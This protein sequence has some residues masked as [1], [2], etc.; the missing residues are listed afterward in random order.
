MS[1]KIPLLHSQNVLHSEKE[2][3][4]EQCQLLGFMHMNI[5]RHLNLPC[6]FSHPESCRCHEQPVMQVNVHGRSPVNANASL[7][8]RLPM[9]VHLTHF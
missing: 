9:H 3:E 1:D 5:F 2:G 6:A 8:Q 7:H 4:G